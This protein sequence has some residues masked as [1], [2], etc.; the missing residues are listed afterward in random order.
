MTAKMHADERDVDESLV[1][2]LI[3]ARFPQ[4]AELPLARVRSDG[5][6]NAIYRLGDDLA[7]R[8]PR[9]PAAA[10]QPSKEA[11][12]LPHLAARLPLQVPEP[13]GLGEPALGYPWHWSV[14]RWIHGERASIEAVDPHEAAA[15]LAAFVRAL[16]EVDPAGGPG[17]GEH[18]F[19]RGAPLATRDQEVRAALARL[20][21]VV[22]VGAAAAAWDRALSAPVWERPGV[23]VHGDLQ[24]GNMVVAGGRLRGIIDFGALGVGDPACDVMTAWIFLP[25]SVRDVFRAEAGADEETW[26]RARGWA[27]SVALIA[28]PYYRETNPAFFAS[29]R[30]WAEE[31]LADR[32]N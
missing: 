25:R 14:C 13:L 11:R 6:D 3:A 28:L 10:A 5:T 27:L 8:L 21:G 4:W 7:V 23:W 22:D 30:R 17:P 9:Y 1:R 29:A 15:Q 12:W 31:V 16:H 26:E 18:N 20:D 24:A 19:A 2:A 32:D